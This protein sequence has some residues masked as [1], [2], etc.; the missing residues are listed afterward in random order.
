M[1]KKEKKENR[2]NIDFV[3]I[4]GNSNLNG[5]NTSIL[6]VS[7]DKS[8]MTNPPA[9]KWFWIIKNENGKIIEIK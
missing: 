4:G 3:R 7:R 2:L 8:L 1:E 5:D 6:L 9:Y